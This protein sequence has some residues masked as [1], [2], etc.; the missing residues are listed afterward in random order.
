M[1]GQF[2]GSDSRPLIGF[3]L[4]ARGWPKL[5]LNFLSDACDETDQQRRG[6][7]ITDKETIIRVGTGAPHVMVADGDAAASVRLCKTVRRAFPTARLFAAS[8]GDE[9]LRYIL[10][11]RPELVF[12]DLN[13]V[14]VGGAE[15]V[16][17]A[18][19]KHVQPLT[20]LTSPR[21][22]KQWVT[23][24]QE[25]G[26]FEFLINP[27]CHDHVFGLLKAI[28][29]MNTPLRSLTVLGGERTRNLVRTRLDQ[30]RFNLQIDE[31]DVGDHAVALGHMTDYDI[32][33]I[34]K[35]IKGL[36]SHDTVRSLTQ[37]R[38]R[39]PV[40]MLAAPGD[41]SPVDLT[42]DLPR[43][44][45]LEM[46]FEAH[47]IDD[48]LYEIFGLRRTYLFNTISRSHRRRLQ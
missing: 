43:A 22:F 9:A 37:I 47:D 29:Q 40:I 16:A 28:K 20:I 36:N 34:E 42:K 33:F 3:E 21:P 23:L 4:D 5:W 13:L 6:S 41:K 25:L 2:L 14:S 38:P 35:N 45:Y 30:S 12:L 27:V 7:H 48:V 15:I 8:R 1:S 18:Q 10:Q 39:L 26:I 44:T 46:P 32:C 17:M 31:T 19:K 11:E 24:C